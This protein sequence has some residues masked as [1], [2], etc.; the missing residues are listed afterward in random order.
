[1]RRSA[2][3]QSNAPDSLVYASINGQ[4]SVLG[5]ESTSWDA[6]AVASSRPYC[7]PGWVLPWWD[8]LRPEG[9]T[10]RSVTV[11]QGSELIGHMP[12][13]LSKDRWGIVTGHVLGHDTA[14]YSEPLAL[15]GRQ[16]QVAAAVASL[17]SGRGERIDVL[18]LTGIPHD[19]PWPQFLQETWPGP[20]PKLSLVSTMQAPFVDVPPGGFDEWFSGRSRNFRQQ[21]RSRRREFLRRGGRFTRAETADEILSGLRNLERLHLGRWSARGG[22]Q[23]LVPGVIQMLTQVSN[24]LGPDRIH[25]WTAEVDGTAVAAALLV[26]AGKEMHYW[27]GGFDEAWASLSLSVLL[28][29]EAVRH[30]AEREYGRVS[31]G[32]GA[33]PY[34]YRLATGEERLDWIDLLPVGRRYPYV[35]L[36]QSPSR[37]YHLAV[38]RTPPHVKQRFRSA[39]RRLFD[40][41]SSEIGKGE[42]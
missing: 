27:L 12:L 23:A 17:L 18:S 14:S 38:R 40:R 4:R 3:S 8:H 5:E 30:A 31:L 6:L 35:R 33:Q 9:S 24:E 28:L 39:A 1:M 19:S 41:P 37:L 34:K 36:I 22:S 2:S 16:R 13:C 25:I 29:V 26:S 20:R 32:P 42:D 10:L 11:R 21:A 15:A 7:A